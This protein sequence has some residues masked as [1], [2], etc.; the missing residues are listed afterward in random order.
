MKK[1]AF[2]ALLTTI[3]LSFAGQNHIHKFVKKKLHLDFYLEEA[4][5]LVSE[6]HIVRGKDNK[7]DQEIDKI[8]A[9]NHKITEALIQSIT[10]GTQQIKAELLQAYDKT[11]APHVYNKLTEQSTGHERITAIIVRHLYLQKMNKEFAALKSEG[12]K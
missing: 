2:L 7:D 9:H 11:D 4:L 1:V 3:N 12:K 5:K 6:Y 10:G 8:E